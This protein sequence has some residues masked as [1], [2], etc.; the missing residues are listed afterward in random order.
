AFTQSIV[1]QLADRYAGFATSALNKYGTTVQVEQYAEENR[2]NMVAVHIDTL[3][4]GGV[5]PQGVYN[6]ALREPLDEWLGKD[7][8][9][10]LLIL[11]DALDEALTFGHPS[12]VTLLAG[13][14]DLPRGVR[15]LLTSRNDPRVTDQFAAVL[16]TGAACRLDLSSEALAG[17]NN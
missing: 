12:I 3:I 1:R 4:L 14:N 7:P 17:K 11:V 13:S 9:Q 10:R 5:N 15:F 16:T 6:R 8:T 2:G